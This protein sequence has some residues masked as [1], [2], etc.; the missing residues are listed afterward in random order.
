MCCLMPVICQDIIPC[1]D[2]SSAPV[3][4]LFKDQYRHYGL[5]KARVVFTI[6][7]L[8]FG[9]Q[10]ITKAM[11]F[12]DK[13][14]TV[15]P[16]YAREISGNPSIAS[17][18][19]KFHG[20]LNGIDPDMWDPY[21]D[22]FIQVSYTSENV[23]EGKKAAKEALQ[24]RLGL[25]RDNLPMIGIIS[26]LT[27]QKGIHLIKHAIWRTLERGGQIYA[28]ADFILV[29]SIFEPCGL[30]QLTAMR[31]GLIPIVR[32]TGGLYDTVFDADHDKERAQGHGL[33]PNGFNFD[34]A[35]AAGVDYALN[36]AISA[37]YDGR[38]WL[39]SL[40]KRVMQ[41]DWSWNRPALDY[42]EL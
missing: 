30:T 35:D 40:C 42:L 24:Q 37:W 17:N 11:E 27:H 5:G 28:G 16:T 13:A 20:I 32:K 36:R 41:Q 31:Y 33:E 39:N 26:R 25:K 38:E 22:K 10:L 19:F 18:I 23:V 7:N 3:A 1:H 6:H 29:P 8:E 4:Q 34:G 21:N 12:S 2:W 15:S 9:A 14:T